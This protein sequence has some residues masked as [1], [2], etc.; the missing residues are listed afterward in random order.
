[1]PL[2]PNEIIQWRTLI[3]N[4]DF[5]A[6]R[7]NIDQ[8]RDDQMSSDS[9]FAMLQI[10]KKQPL[11]RALTKWLNTVISTSTNTTPNVAAVK[12][13]PATKTSNERCDVTVNGVC[14]LM[15][16]L[17][18]TFLVYIRHCEGLWTKNHLTEDEIGDLKT[19][20]RIFNDLPN[21][22]FAMA[23]FVMFYAKRL[24]EIL[25]ISLCCMGPF[26]FLY[27]YNF[28]KPLPIYEQ[29]IDIRLNVDSLST[30]M[31]LYTLGSVVWLVCTLRCPMLKQ[32]LNKV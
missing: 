26:L 1:M 4:A 20:V 13:C 25:R 24:H 2:S 5:K 6:L 22:I 31:S 15:L 17:Y 8:L 27:V 10:P 7:S 21:V 23:L 32:W 28:D 18:S 9:R 29:N 19:S 14:V 11:K 12:A 16:I 30:F 3:D